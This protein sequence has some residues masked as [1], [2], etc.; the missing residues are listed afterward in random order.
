MRVDEYAMKQFRQNGATPQVSAGPSLIKGE[1]PSHMV[2]P[3]STN[4]SPL[5][6][7]LQ[8]AMGTVADV[9]ILNL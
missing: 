9:S 2:K 8:G 3:N 1:L 6:D 4:Q 5:S 7:R